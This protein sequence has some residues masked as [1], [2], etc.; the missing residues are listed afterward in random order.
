MKRLSLLVLAAAAAVVLPAHA[1]ARPYAGARDAVAAV[2]QC[3]LP[4]RTTWWID[5]G[6]PELLHV[7]GKPGVIVTS[8]SGDFPNRVKA[9]GAHTLYWD[10]YLNRRVG[11]PS[12][13]TDPGS[14]VERADRLF[15][16]AAQQTG[17]EKP[18]IVLNE[19]NGAHL[20]TP[21][22]ATN[23]GYRANVLALVR[24][25]AE[26]G[27]RSF[28]L[29]SRKAYLGSDEA[30]AWWRETAQ[31]ADLVS[32][33]Y[34]PAPSVH[35]MGAIAGSRRIRMAMRDRIDRF[36]GIGIPRTK[37]GIVVGFQTGSGTGGREGL[38]PKEAW[39]EYVKL[40]A[41]AAKQ[42]VQETGIASVISWGWQSYSAQGQDPDREAAACVYLWTRDASLCDGPRAAGPAFNASLTEG[43][44]RLPA[45]RVCTIGA[46]AIG[47][48]SL[49]ALERVTADREV[50]FSA[51]LARLAES[52]HAKVATKRVLAAERA[53][54]AHRFNG[55][56]AAYAAALAR[57]GATLAIARDVLADELRRA[58]LV[59]QMRGRGPSAAEVAAFYSGY[60]DLL[61]RKV[62]AKPA[63]PWLGG[64]RS[65]LALGEFA[66]DPVFA[67]RTGVKARVLLL[68]GSYEIVARD[69]PQPLGTVPFYAARSAIATA[70]RSFARRERFEAWSVA[71]QS[72]ALTNAICRRDELPAPAAILLS[73]Y[74][75]FLALA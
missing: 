54:V 11:T 70:L 57:A 38:R 35:R 51:L 7:F 16:F 43:Q 29:I 1:S 44:L 66:P 12:A 73:G 8:S 10:M 62:E 20:E 45:G 32:E 13:P 40:N 48:A 67:L 2:G 25:L 36:M 59:S 28:L 65:G 50:A 63:P 17:C 52:P 23:A 6:T 41:L 24:R 64:R 34:F 72:H 74:L 5:F 37:L 46:R 42:I 69:D 49:A 14:I 3:G 27:A 47:A 39:F 71:R 18:L 58:D 26:R 33:V 30:V 56:R 4:S 75:P 21:W 68:D 31:Y 15:D 53:V 60:P 55:S 9:A 61:V 19:L 22:S